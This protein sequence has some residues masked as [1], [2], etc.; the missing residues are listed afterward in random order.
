M[1]RIA[2]EGCEPC[3]WRNKTARSCDA[4]FAGVDDETPSHELVDQA[5]PRIQQAWDAQRKRGIPSRLRD[6]VVISGSGKPSLAK[7]IRR[8]LRAADNV[9]GVV[10]LKPIPLRFA[11]LPDPVQG[12]LIRPMTI[13]LEIVISDHC[14]HPMMS[15]LHEVGHLIDMEVFCGVSNLGPM[16]F[17][18]EEVAAA[19][20]ALG[21]MG[22]G[23]HLVDVLLTVLPEVQRWNAAVSSSWRVEEIEE[24]AD[25]EP[26]DPYFPYL[27]Q[28]DELFARSYAQWV[29]VHAG[30]EASIRS[31]KFSAGR[32]VSKSGIGRTSRRS[33]THWT[34]YCFPASSPPG[35]KSTPRGSTC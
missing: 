15:V 1:H 4:T 10:G 23:S 31:W 25:E 33:A 20:E 8:A 11:A 29:A 18:A 22:F 6:A 12:L 3:L 28:R 32:R 19:K 27:L 34:N 26:D 9:H 14:D 5:L 24:L 13:P 16:N 30:D 7:K 35:L 17:R 21:C 2:E